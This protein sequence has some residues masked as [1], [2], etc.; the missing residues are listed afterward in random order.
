MR[1]KNSYINSR[2]WLYYFN[3]TQREAMI[4]KNVA[5][6]YFPMA[7]FLF[8]KTTFFTRFVFKCFS[9]NKSSIFLLTR[10]VRNS[11][12]SI[13]NLNTLDLEYFEWEMPDV[14]D[15]VD[16]ERAKKSVIRVICKLQKWFLWRHLEAAEKERENWGNSTVLNL[17]MGSVF[18]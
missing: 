2:Q 8:H 6:I 15:Y 13:I 14:D 17:I 10:L 18:F 5:E 12:V 4:K 16:E 1:N 7:K 3:A 11:T 9:K